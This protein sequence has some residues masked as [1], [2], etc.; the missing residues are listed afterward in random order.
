MGG[1]LIKLTVWKNVFSS[2]IFLD[3]FTPSS[4]ESSVCPKFV[5]MQAPMLSLLITVGS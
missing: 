2:N 1:S 5:H 4:K 3:S